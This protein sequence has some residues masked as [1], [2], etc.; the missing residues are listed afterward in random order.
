MQDRDAAAPILAFRR[1]SSAASDLAVPLVDVEGDDE[2]ATSSVTELSAAQIGGVCG[3]G[4]HGGVVGGMTAFS[5]PQ[6]D[7]PPLP[8]GALR[9]GGGVPTPVKVVDVHPKYPPLARHARIEGVVAL[10]ATFDETGRVVDVRV[11]RSTT[12]LD[13]A[14]IEAIRKWRYAPV[15]VNGRAVAVLMTVTAHFVL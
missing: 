14:A 5:L 8:A 4:V 9:V 6:V 15:M 13:R 1:V 12:A 2:S 3:C 10:D 11:L 7:L